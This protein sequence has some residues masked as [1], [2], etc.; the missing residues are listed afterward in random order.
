MRP[1]MQSKKH[2]S[3]NFGHSFRASNEVSRKAT[4]Y[5]SQTPY[6]LDQRLPLPPP[7]LIITYTP[8]HPSNSPACPIFPKLLSNN[9]TSVLPSLSS[10]KSPSPSFAFHTTSSP[11]CPLF[12]FCTSFDCTS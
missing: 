3:K 4:G 9:L 6:T 8:L 12:P 11:S 5:Q 2:N 7:K 10:F 1:K